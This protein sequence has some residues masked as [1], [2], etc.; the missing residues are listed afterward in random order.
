[1]ANVKAE[2][3]EKW[4]SDNPE[5]L[6]NHASGLIFCTKCESHVKATCK[7]NVKRHVKGAVH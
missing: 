7:G 3:V 4:I 1:M 2:T 6:Y 5:L